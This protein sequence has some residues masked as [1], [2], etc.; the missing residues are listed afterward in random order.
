P[1]FE[2]VVVDDG[3]YDNTT[4]VALRAPGVRYVRQENMGPAGARNA[5]LRYGRGSYVVFLHADDRLLP[6]A[7]EVGLSGLADNPACAFVS[8]QCRHIAFDGSPLPVETPPVI[9]R[10]PYHELLR[11]CYIWTPGV[12]MFRRV[13]FSWAGGFD[14]AFGWNDD[15]EMYLRIARS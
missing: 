12:V 4:E 11:N 1:H 6:E 15:Y 10:D 14:P 5:G 3:S 13:A 2:V 9:P 7:L 8:G